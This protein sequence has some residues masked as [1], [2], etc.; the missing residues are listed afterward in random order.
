MIIRF[1]CG[2]MMESMRTGHAAF[3]VHN[4]T[5]LLLYL[6]TGS[7]IISDGNHR[8]GNG[9]PIKYCPFCGRKIQTGMIKPVDERKAL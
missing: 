4:E 3:K 8:F 2:K 6:S 5:E 7:A 1:C 9:V